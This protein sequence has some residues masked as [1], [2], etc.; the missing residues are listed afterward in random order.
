[1]VDL[2]FGDL[3][4]PDFPSDQLASV[5]RDPYASSYES[6]FLDGML[7]TTTSSDAS[8]EDTYTPL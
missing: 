7:S 6:R 2:I 5:G 4:R 8:V 3:G 1:M